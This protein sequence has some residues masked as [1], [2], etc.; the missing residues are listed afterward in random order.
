MKIQEFSKRTGVPAKTIRYYE[1]IGLPPKPERSATG[2]RRYAESTVEVLRFIRKAQAL[3]FS[4]DEVGEMSLRMQAMLLRFLENG[5]IQAVGSDGRTTRVDVRV[6]AATNADLRERVEG[7][8]FRE[9]LYYRLNSLSLSIPSLRD[10]MEDIAIL[11]EHFIERYATEHG[12]HVSVLAA[13]ALEKLI[14]YSWPGNVREL[15]SVITRAL[16]FAKARVLRAEDIELPLLAAARAPQTRSL[17]EAK[18]KTIE[19]FEHRYLASVMTQHQGNVT[20]AAKAAGKERRAFQRLLR[21]HHINRDS[22]HG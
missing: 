11:T 13:D 10:R 9:D 15:E 18:N 17:R 4:L 8:D 14:G 2:Y 22:F 20:R 16:T 6:I 1:E 3:G 21:K 19:E 7:K 12:Q 5:E